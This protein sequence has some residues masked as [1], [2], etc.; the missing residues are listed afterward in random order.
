MKLFNLQTDWRTSLKRW[1]L[2]G[3]VSYGLI[4]LLTVLGSLAFAWWGAWQL[5]KDPMEN[6]PGVLAVAFITDR[7]LLWL[8]ITGA[9]ALAPLLDQ[10][11]AKFRKN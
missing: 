3:V 11:I 2:A 1:G 9:L 6:L 5:D 7:A 4:S 8:R 10:G